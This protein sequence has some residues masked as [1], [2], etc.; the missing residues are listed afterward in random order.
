MSELTVKKN[1]LSDEAVN[2]CYDETTLSIDQL[3]FSYDHKTILKNID[4]HLRSGQVVGLIGPNG[5]G[6]STLLHLMLGLLKPQE[7]NISINGKN[8][9]NKKRKDLARLMTFVPQD[10]NINYAFSVEDVVAMGRNP[11]IDRFQPASIDDVRIIEEAMIQT[12]VLHF[13][14]RWINQLSGGE[15]QRVLIARAIA[16]QTPIIILDEATANLDICHQLDVLELARSLAQAGRLV[17]IAMHDLNMAS[18]F[19]E[20]L[21]LLAENGVQA[22]G[23]PDDVITEE[24]LKR[25]FHLQASVCPQTL[26]GESQGLSVAAIKSMTSGE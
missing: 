5:V 8:L 20:R 24:N 25:Y 13:S 21:V 7:G 15:R 17:I 11:W 6:K 12:D 23:K 22:D 1:S 18:R 14:K 26:H 16:Q 4:L 9:S 2:A 19:C 3:N 10:S